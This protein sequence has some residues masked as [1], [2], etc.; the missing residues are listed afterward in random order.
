MGLGRLLAAALLVAGAATSTATAAETAL[1]GARIYLAPDAPAIESGTILIRD[2]RIAAVGRSGER[3]DDGGSQRG[4]E[5]PV[6]RHRLEAQPLRRGR[7]QHGRRQCAAGKGDQNRKV[8]I[9]RQS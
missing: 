6:R 8:S 4:G 5:R 2:G 7:P 1:V 9:T 3:Q